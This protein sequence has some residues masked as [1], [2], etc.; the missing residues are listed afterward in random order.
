M[1]EM[2]REEKMNEELFYINVYECDGRR[3]T[4]CHNSRESAQEELLNGADAS[5]IDTDYIAT[6]EYSDNM[7]FGHEDHIFHLEDE[8]LDMRDEYHFD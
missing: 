8:V 2:I 4:T 6:I 3:E 7:I 1:R 5:G